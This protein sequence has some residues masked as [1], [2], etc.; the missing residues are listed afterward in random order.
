MAI[1]RSV[2]GK[3]YEVPDKNLDKYEIPADQLR[4][5]LGDQAQAEP[6]PSGPGAGSG[7]PGGGGGSQVVIQIHGGGG[8]QGGGAQGG[9]GADNGEE[10][11][12]YWGWWRN[13]L[14][15]LLAQQ[16]AELLAQLL[17]TESLPR[18]AYSAGPG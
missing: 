11:Q 7:G 4:E 17:L 15:Q 18:P 6:G 14:A 5:K 12:P 1:L 10:V 8:A 13:L 9:A 3:F 16:L 2:D